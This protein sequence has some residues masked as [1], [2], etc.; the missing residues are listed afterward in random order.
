MKCV[1][2]GAEY[3]PRRANKPSQYC[4]EKCRHAAYRRT[5]KE[6]ICRMN[7]KYYSAHREEI[8]LKQK[9]RQ[10]FGGK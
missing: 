2:C 3:K 1:E 6:L 7:R 9:R 8:Y 5:H 4:S 10:I